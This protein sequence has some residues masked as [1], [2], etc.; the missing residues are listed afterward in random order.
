MKLPVRPGHL[1]LWRGCALVISPGIDST[2]H[3]HFALQ[4][5]YGLDRPFRAR[6][7]PD[8]PWTETRSACFAANR[9]HQIDSDGGMLAHLFIEL[10]R[11]SQTDFTSLQ[12][13]F[14]QHPAFAAIA[15]TLASKAATLDMQGADELRLA[16]QA[17]ALPDGLL[18]T[19]YD[20]RISQALAHIHAQGDQQCTGASLA[21][22]VHLSE[23]RFTHLFRQ[24]TGMTLSRYLLWSRMLDAVAFVAEGQNMTAAAH[25]SGFADLAHMSRTF[26]S[27][28]GVAP[29]ELHRMAIAFKRDAV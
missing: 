20:I 14:G 21:R 6:L 17:C 18:T 7:S 2:P 16:W 5:S 22:Q 9:S 26:R 1:F 13:A 15:A 8:Q 23:S 28:M 29:S 24:Q 3:A 27:M 19:N 4:L 25:E 11:T 12:A 10:P